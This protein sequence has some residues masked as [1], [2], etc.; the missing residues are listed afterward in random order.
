[1]DFAESAELAPDRDR[2]DP[3]TDHTK[4]LA[5]LNAAYTQAFD[6][7]AQI[8]RDIERKQ[9]D[10]SKMKEEQIVFDKSV[11]ELQQAIR[12]CLGSRDENAL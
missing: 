10:M 2:F 12:N 6:K 4:E 9:Q 3:S 8:Q 1:M 5:K 7:R 11:A